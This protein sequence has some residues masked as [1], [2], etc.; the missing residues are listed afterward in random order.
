MVENRTFQD[1]LTGRRPA[2]A[3]WAR[4]KRIL[5]LHILCDEASD[6]DLATSYSCFEEQF[7]AAE[8]SIDP[9]TGSGLSGSLTLS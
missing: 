4:G 2:D 3:S 1:T 8:N 6:F 7:V 5:C 9:Q